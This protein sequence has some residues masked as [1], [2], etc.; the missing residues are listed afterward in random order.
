MFLPADFRDFLAILIASKVRFMLV[1]GY[2]YNIH[3]E[4]RVTQDIDVWV[5]PTRE[6][7]LLVRDSLQ[8]FIGAD[9]EVEQGLELLKTNRLGFGV[10]IK[11]NRA[12]VLLRVKGV[13]FNDAYPRSMQVEVDGLVFQVIHPHDQIRN[14]RAAG[15]FKDL[16]DVEKL[17]KVYGEP[18]S[19]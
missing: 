16:A 14:K 5:E 19:Q 17:L 11:P 3:V 15:R 10:G 6:N 8:E 4:A 13:E 18:P 2:A 7:L 12:E 1:G 9:F